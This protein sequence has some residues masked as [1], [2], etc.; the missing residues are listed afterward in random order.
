[1]SFCKKGDECRSLNRIKGLALVAGNCKG[2][3]QLFPFFY[4]LS[5]GIGI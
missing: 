3:E 5:W 4:A 2:K 1:M